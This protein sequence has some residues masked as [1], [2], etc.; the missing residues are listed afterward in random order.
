MSLCSL[1][2]ITDKL[3]A[4]SARSP[5]EALTRSRWWRPRW[6]CAWRLQHKYSYSIGF[7]VQATI[8]PQLQRHYN[9]PL[10]A[11]AG[12]YRIM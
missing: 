2:I 3:N 8:Y 12:S 11:T 9:C 5:G 7:T 1:L 6:L 10:T 4:V